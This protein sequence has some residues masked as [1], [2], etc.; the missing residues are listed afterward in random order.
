MQIPHL[1]EPP[2]FRSLIR[3]IPYNFGCPACGSNEF[4]Q[5][6]GWLQDN[7]HLS[8]P[9]CKETIRFDAEQLRGPVDA[10]SK[11]LEAFWHSVTQYA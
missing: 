1:A 2:D 9:V 6:L 7:Q 11:G 5:T 4:Q 8:C 10:F 3:G